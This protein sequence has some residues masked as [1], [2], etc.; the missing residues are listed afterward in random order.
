MLA[1]LGLSLTTLFRETRDRHDSDQAIRRFREGLALPRLDPDVVLRLHVG[2][3]EHLLARSV[4]LIERS[5]L[6]D[7][8]DELRRTLVLGFAEE[9]RLPVTFQL[10]RRSQLAFVCRRLSGAL[11]RRSQ[12]AT[13]TAS[14]TEDMLEAV[15]VAEAT[16]SPLLLRAL[17]H[18]TQ[19]G[20]PA[21]GDGFLEGRELSLLDALDS[22]ELAERDTGIA[23][24]E[25]LRWM[26]QRYGMH[27]DAAGAVDALR[28]RVTGARRPSAATS[29][30][31]CVRP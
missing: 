2:L 24:D 29:I 4:L 31:G 1:N 17:L 8:V 28:D 25:Q 27:R 13:D 11:L 14:S 9:A 16:K 5:A 18:R 26:G 6:D 22:A 12:G 30:P 15:A 19:A 21:T 3:G 7:A 20:D 10:G 23:S